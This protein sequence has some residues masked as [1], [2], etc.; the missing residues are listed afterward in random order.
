MLVLHIL[1]KTV[2]DFDTIVIEI[3]LLFYFTLSIYRLDNCISDIY[4]SFND[5][6]N[7]ILAIY[8]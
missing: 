5:S 3:I 6:W 7:N 4:M 1:E 2:H 8:K